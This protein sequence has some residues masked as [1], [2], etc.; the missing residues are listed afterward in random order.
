MLGVP[1]HV[2]KSRPGPTLP[3]RYSRNSHHDG[4]GRVMRT[5]RFRKRRATGPAR[6]NPSSLRFAARVDLLGSFD[7]ARTMDRSLFRLGVFQLGGPLR[8][9][10]SPSRPPRP[11]HGTSLFRLTTDGA[12]IS[13][14][15]FRTSGGTSGV[16]SPARNPIGPQ[17]DSFEG[18]SL[19]SVRVVL[20]WL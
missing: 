13:T 17:R 9:G 15:L 10:E 14:R 4:G 6:A 8:S 16:V 5:V 19:L 2:A 18:G 11:R 12:S 3:P 20:F 7:F 1:G